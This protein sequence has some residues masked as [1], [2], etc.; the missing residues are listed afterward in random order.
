MRKWT[1]LFFLASLI[2][3]VQNVVL[4]MIYGIKVTLSVVIMS[5]IFGAI[6]TALF[7]RLK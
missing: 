6:F 4:L 7:R 3:M 1:K 2:D 5:F